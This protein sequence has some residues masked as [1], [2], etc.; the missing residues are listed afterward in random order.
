MVGRFLVGPIGD[1]LAGR[2]RISKG[3]FGVIGLSTSLGLLDI[4][5]EEAQTK[6]FLAAACDKVYGLFDSSK[7]GGFGLHSFADTA[8]LTGLFTDDGIGADVV[9]QWN[10]ADVPVSV[11]PSHPATASVVE[12]MA[13]RVGRSTRL[14]SVR[15]RS[16]STPLQ[17]QSP[18]TATAHSPA[19]S[20]V[21]SP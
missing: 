10:S 17:L 4:S 6:S 15:N 13:D 20:S 9:A 21:S 8:R 2:G 16:G 3:F 5:A 19:R 7:V 1:V 11:A 12:L 14:S 18:C